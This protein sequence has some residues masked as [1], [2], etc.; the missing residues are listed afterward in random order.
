MTAQAMFSAAGGT[1]ALWLVVHLI[2]GGKEVERP[3]RTSTVLDTVLRDTLHLCWHC[4]T[5]TAAIIGAFR[6]GRRLFV[7]RFDGR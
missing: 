1:A 4:I 7:L 3:L 2:L 6:V 5:V